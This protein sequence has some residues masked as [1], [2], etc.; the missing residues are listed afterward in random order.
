MIKIG[1]IDLYLI[2]LELIKKGLSKDEIKK[3]ENF[4]KVYNDI[5]TITGDQVL[6]PYF[7]RAKDCM[8]FITNDRIENYQNLIELVIELEKEKF[9][10]HKLTTFFG[11]EDL[12]EELKNNILELTESNPYLKSDIVLYSK[13]FYP[14]EFNTSYFNNISLV[15]NKSKNINME[16]IM[17]V[18]ENV[19]FELELAYHKN[20]TYNY[21]SKIISVKK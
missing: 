17:D 9:N 5:K 7:K 10:I 13:L 2:Y 4:N 20:K 8:N 6:A 3:D 1:F 14:I 16:D 18:L 21:I 12:T 15:L 11:F 19:K